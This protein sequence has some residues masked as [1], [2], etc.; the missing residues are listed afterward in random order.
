VIVIADTT[1]LHYLILLDHAEIL[2][3]LYGCVIIPD[4]VARELQAQRTPAP[5]RQWMASPRGWLEVRQITVPT[6]PALA[7]LDAGE[8][9][10][11]ALAEALRAD[12]VIIDERAG[13]REAERRKLR[14]IGTLRVLD[15]AAQAGLVDLP[16]A[17]ERLRTFGFYVDTKLMQF[18][19][20]RH[21]K[22]TPR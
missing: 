3:E 2:R 22:R 13:R 5:V 20:D 12:A 18:L 7:D 19:L 1:P 16:D 6:D 21:S 14:V 11:I 4:A 17:L 9:E 10:A 15:D 8:R